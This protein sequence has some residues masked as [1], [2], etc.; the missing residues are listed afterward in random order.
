M[1][2]P[3]GAEVSGN[4]LKTDVLVTRR[5]AL[6][7]GLAAPLVS[8]FAWCAQYA[9]GPP[10]WVAERGTARVFLFGQMAVRARS[11]WLSSAIER[12]FDA[13]TELWTE[14]PD[15][16]QGPSSKTVPPP[17]KGPKLIEVASPQDM[18]RLHAVLVR[19]GMAPSAFDGLALSAAYPAVSELADRAV[20]AD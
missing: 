17:P 18:A 2:Q 9:P 5:R 10:L 15:P 11:P 3:F 6:D 12:A 4:V 1:T 13:S 19:E 7:L 16:N 8:P 20:G 14:N